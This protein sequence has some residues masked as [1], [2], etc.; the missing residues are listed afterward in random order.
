MYA[1]SPSVGSVSNTI[2]MCHLGLNAFRS[3]CSSSSFPCPHTTP[4][5]SF[6]KWAFQ[7]ETKQKQAESIC[8]FTVQ[9]ALGDSL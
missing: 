6:R 9:Q 1:F 8:R 3:D 4:Y 7:K 2:I 5:P